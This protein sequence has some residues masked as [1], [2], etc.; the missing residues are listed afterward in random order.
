LDE[1]EE[2]AMAAENEA[3]KADSF[4][5]EAVLKAPPTATNETIARN[6]RVKNIDSNQYVCQKTAVKGKGVRY[7][8]NE[9]CAKFFETLAKAQDKTKQNRNDQWR[10]RNN[11][12]IAGK[13]SESGAERKAAA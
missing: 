13:V 6:I 12:I 5:E 3:A 10:V 4:N 1:G 11:K 2:A 8:L 9:K 7:L